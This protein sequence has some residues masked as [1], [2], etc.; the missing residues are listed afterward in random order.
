MWCVCTVVVVEGMGMDATCSRSW[1]NSSS[2]CSSATACSR[3]PPRVLVERAAAA[4]VA[5]NLPTHSAAAV[6][7][8]LTCAEEGVS[9][10]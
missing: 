9:R 5:S 7:S 3:E 1:S 4:T 8:M 10:G 6:K 2:G